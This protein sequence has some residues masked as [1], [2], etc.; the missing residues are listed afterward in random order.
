MK[1]RS[2][3]FRK[4]AGLGL[5]GIACIL[6]EQRNETQAQE[7]FARAHQAQ[8]AGDL[9]TAI[10]EYLDSKTAKLD[11]LAAKVEAAVERLQEY[12]TALITAAV[13]G[14]IDVRKAVK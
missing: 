8:N 4:V 14:K 11:A 1:V 12:R 7:H 6:A 13:T 9:Q 2:N 5:F 10:A 3:R